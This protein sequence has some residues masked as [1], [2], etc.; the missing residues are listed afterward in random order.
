MLFADWIF[1]GHGSSYSSFLRQTDKSFKDFQGGKIFPQ[2]YFFENEDL[3]ESPFRR[4][5]WGGQI[6]RHVKEDAQRP[7]FLQT[8]TEF[9]HTTTALARY[10]PK[11]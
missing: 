10:Q 3:T 2:D 4:A 5:A 9:F 8:K 1:D 6:Y 11:T 7:D